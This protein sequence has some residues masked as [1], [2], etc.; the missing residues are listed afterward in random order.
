LKE[1]AFIGGL[2][3]D[4]RLEGGGS[5]TV[6]SADALLRLGKN[7][8]LE[9]QTAASR[10]DEPDD[11]ALTAD[12]D[13]VTF[14]DDRHTLAFDDETFWGRGSYVSLERG[15][16]LWSFDLDY[17]DYDPSFRTDN[18]F[19]TRNDYRQASG[20]TALSFRPGSEWLTRAQPDIGIG[21]VWS[22]DGQFKDEWIRPTFWFITKGQTEIGGQ[23]LISR[24]RFGPETFPGIRIWSFWAD[25]TPTEMVSAGFNGNVGRGI[26]R[27]FDDP[28]LADQQFWGVFVRIKPSRKVEV[29]T[30]WDY[31][32]MDSR[33]RD[34][35]LFAGWLLRN[36]LSVNFTREWF[37]RLVVQY[38]EFDDRLD[39]EPL[40]T[41]RI[42]PFTV[43]FVGSVN[44]YRYFDRGEFENLTSSEWR[45]S[46]RQFFAKL[47]Y[48][49]QI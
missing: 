40:L 26:Y 17:W 22:T 35:N 15:A 6:L 23:Y 34:E 45:N 38:D 46:S 4:R 10:T 42:N 5:G 9:V 13:P 48:L 18:G 30:D 16:R 44:R 11:P 3:T 32:R 20:W 49:L 28:E 14:D 2:V 41:Y 33:E 31:A 24:E 43:F 1:D 27:D 36:R 47:Q 19:T 25:T 37:L 21:R 8:R 39:V 7:Y 12:L 29:Q